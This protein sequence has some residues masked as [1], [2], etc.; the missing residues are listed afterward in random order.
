L[1]LFWWGGGAAPPPP[2]PPPPTTKGF[3]RE[4][5][6]AHTQRGDGARLQSQSLVATARWWAR[7]WQVQ[8]YSKQV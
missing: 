5:P 6:G 4:R 2:P 8:E 7:G 3:V 1:V